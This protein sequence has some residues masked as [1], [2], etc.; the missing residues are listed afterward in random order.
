MKS[1]RGA[2]KLYKAQSVRDGDT[3]YFFLDDGIEQDRSVEQLKMLIRQSLPIIR[4]HVRRLLRDDALVHEYVDRLYSRLK[5]SLHLIPVLNQQ[6]VKGRLI[7][8]IHEDRRRQYKRFD[9]SGTDALQRR[10][11]PRSL[12]FIT[13]LV[14]RDQLNAFRDCLYPWMRTA[15]D[16]RFDFAK[17]LR[18]KEIAKLFKISRSVFDKKWQRGLEAAIDEYIKRYG[19]WM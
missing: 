10:A 8:L 11:D 18:S 16:L 15:F 13:D 12:D 1:D 6:V 5:R 14:R 3:E 4:D 9:S 7:S 19:S 17:P 2:L